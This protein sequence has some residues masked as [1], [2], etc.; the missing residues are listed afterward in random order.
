[1][2]D[3]RETENCSFTGNTHISEK[4]SRCWWQLRRVKSP[5]HALGTKQN[6]ILKIRKNDQ[7]HHSTLNPL[8]IIRSSSR[9]I[10][11]S[12]VIGSI[13]CDLVCIRHDVQNIGDEICVLFY[14]SIASFK[15]IEKQ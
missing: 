10:R 11:L 8:W 1:M 15:V 13:V 14:L 6:I 3:A 2:S 7:K 4:K 5:H 12:S 9:I